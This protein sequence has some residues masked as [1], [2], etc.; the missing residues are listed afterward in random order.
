MKMQL[1]SNNAIGER[2]KYRDFQVL[3]DSI[4]E[5]NN[6]RNIHSIAAMVGRISGALLPC[7]EGGIG[8]FDQHEQR[9]TLWIPV[10]FHGD[11]LPVDSDEVYDHCPLSV[12]LINHWI[13]LRQFLFL[14]VTGGLCACQSHAETV[15]HFDAKNVIVDGICKQDAGKVCFY[16]F[17]NV[18]KGELPKYQIIMN[19][20]LSSLSNGLLSLA[21][22]KGAQVEKG[23]AL[24]E[25]ECE[26]LAHIRAG[27]SNKI[28]A[29]RLCISINTVKSHIYNIFQ[30]LHAS[31]RVEA[32]VKAKQ[33]GYLA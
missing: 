19:L 11:R 21:E 33:A 9:I 10:G 3:T 6:P 27:L 12:E 2:I 16:Y 22:Q 18:D 15:G 14:D 17:A 23:E 8:V 25:R 20:L 4:N 7:D 26:I 28:I 31:N 30:K 1:L 13:E 24:T 32:L 29:S 5:I